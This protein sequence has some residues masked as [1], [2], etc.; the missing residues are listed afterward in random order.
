MKARSWTVAS[1]GE[2]LVIGAELLV[3][4]EVV[5]VGLSVVG[6]SMESPSV[7]RDSHPLAAGQDHCHQYTHCYI[8]R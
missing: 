5:D 3:D 2:V 6:E 7:G 8:A 4:V 1:S